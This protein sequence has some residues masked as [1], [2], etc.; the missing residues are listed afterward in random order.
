MI[1]LRYKNNVTFY[2]TLWTIAIPIVIQNF[3]SSS[4]NLVDN[5]MIGQLGETF[6]AATGFANQLFF[7]MV[8]L[9][10]GAGSGTSVYIAQYWGNRDVANIKRV[11]ALGMLFAFIVSLAFFIVGFFFPRHILS[12]FTQDA[13]VI[14]AG[15][16]YMHIVSL[17]YIITGISFVFGFSAR[18]VGK[19]KLPMTASIISLLINT[20]LNYT[21]IFG[22]FGFEPM[23]IRGAAIAT[24]IARCVEIGI[25]L[26]GVYRLVPPIALNVK[27]FFTLTRP[28]TARVV[29]TAFPVILNEGFWSLGMTAYLYFYGKIG[30][31]AVAAVTISN[32]VNSLFMVIGFGLGNASA[33]MLG[34]SLGAGEI[35][36]AID[37]NKKFLVLSMLLGV[38]VSA[39]IIILAPLIIAN[40]YTLTP[41]AYHDTVRTILVI[42]G[43][44]S[45]KFYNTI[46]V[47]GTLR[48]GGDTL[49]S[50]LLEIS[51][52]W[53][54]GVPLSALGAMVFKLPI[55]WVVAL[56]NIE[57]VVK[58]V[59]GLPRIL[60][61]KW[62][63]KLV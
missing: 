23:G 9:L 60:S 28:L 54:I 56:V 41:E 7:I 49:Y 27:D 18:S 33:V 31:N 37:Y 59:A 38:V 21:L 2:K 35:D 8:L 16:D 40:L 48:S 29:R 53:L 26:F 12:I 43:F 51:C 32:V 10:F 61:H 63:Q 3:I 52:V 4:L 1:S 44:M 17:S 13:A 42:S 6:I 24:A 5:I 11:M 20:G 45:F 55:Y 30:T 19:A 50:M 39:L 57:E 46:V 15:A 25:I 62:A 58:L 47:I 22:H 14:A 34:N 36:K